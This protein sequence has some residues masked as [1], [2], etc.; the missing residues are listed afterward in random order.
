MKTGYGYV[1]KHNDHDY[2]AETQKIV[3]TTVKKL[4]RNPTNKDLDFIKK[5]LPRKRK[6]G[7]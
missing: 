6:T 1:N 3:K 7:Y 2:K 4:G 5:S